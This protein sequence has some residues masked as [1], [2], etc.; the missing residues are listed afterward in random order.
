MITMIAGW[1]VKRSLASGG[2]MT[3]AHARRLVK[4]GVVVLAVVALVATVALIRRDAVDDYQADR[5]E[6]AL[7]G[8][9]RANSAGEVREDAARTDSA[10]TVRDLETIHAADPEAAAQPASAGTRRVADRLPKE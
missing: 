1:L 8:E 10:D 7:E 9:Q 3:L 4:I 5:V 6:D 2:G